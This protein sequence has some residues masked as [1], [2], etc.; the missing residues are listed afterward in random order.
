MDIISHRALDARLLDRVARA[1]LGA[2][3]CGV[4]SGADS[5]IHLLTANPPDQRRASDVLNH[6]GRLQLEASTLSLSQGD[7]DPVITCA[8]EQIAADDQLGYLTL[9]DGEESERGRQAITEGAASI[10]LR[11]PAPGDY[12]VLVY[13]LTGNFASGIL[14]IRVDPAQPFKSN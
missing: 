13:R 9:R 5:R 12:T 7:A 11:Q 8:D 6:F 1:A 4:S 10:S 14:R 2:A 3:T